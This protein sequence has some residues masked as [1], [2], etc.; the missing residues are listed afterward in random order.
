MSNL[1]RCG[2][3]AGEKRLSTFIQLYFFTKNVI[4]SCIINLPPPRTVQGRRRRV[5]VLLHVHKRPSGEQRKSLGMLKTSA[6]ALD[7]RWNRSLFGLRRWCLDTLVFLHQGPGVGPV[8][9]DRGATRFSLIPHRRRRRD[10]PYRAGPASVR[11]RL[12]R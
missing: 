3:R 4:L 8:T 12:G 10:G 1:I 7:E 2:E 5:D 11:R 6:V 9:G